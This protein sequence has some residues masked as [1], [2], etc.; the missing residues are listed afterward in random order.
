MSDI[1][2]LRNR[3]HTDAEPDVPDEVVGWATALSEEGPDMPDETTEVA[4]ER[5]YIECVECHK[6]ENI[7]HST[8]TWYSINVF[9]EDQ[10]GGRNV[11][12]W[13]TVCDKKRCWTATMNNIRH[14]EY[15]P[16]DGG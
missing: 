7:N 14:G 8:G 4:D 6:V 12:D 2:Q 1:D 10:R 3:V 15:R 9:E 16:K 5:K 11:A 13:V